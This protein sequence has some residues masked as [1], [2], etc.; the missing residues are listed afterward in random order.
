MRAGSESAHARNRARL[1][2]E[3]ERVRASIIPPRR[4]SSAYT[5]IRGHPHSTTNWSAAQLDNTGPL[6]WEQNIIDRL[7]AGEGIQGVE[8][9]SLF[10]KC[11]LC[12]NYFIAS[13]LRV[14]IRSCAPDL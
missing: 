7:H 4:T 5:R 12:D 2:D 8:M 10:E 11:T 3:S 9:S 14:H 6:V 13:L 1:D